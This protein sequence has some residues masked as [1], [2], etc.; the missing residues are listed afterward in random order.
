MANETE[1]DAGKPDANA[2]TGNKPAVV[3]STLPSTVH[4]LP[5]E[6]FDSRFHI[7]VSATFTASGNVVSIIAPDITS[8][9]LKLYITAPIRITSD[10]VLEFLKA[11]DT[12]LDSK[13]EER[14]KT[15][16]ASIELSAFYY[17]RKMEQLDFT[18]DTGDAKLKAYLKDALK[19]PDAT[20]TDPYIKD[21]K[22]R[23]E[24]KGQTGKY[25]YDRGAFLVM[26]KLSFEQ[27]IISTLVGDP[28]ISKLFDVTD[29]H[30]RV[31]R[32]PPDREGDLQ[33]YAQLLSAG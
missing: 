4:M 20:V 28:S 3:G 1:A 26:F 6:V 10:A 23:N 16:K 19:V 12:V 18:N 29:I 13:I 15:A 17:E 11:R 2:D 27:G 5:A 8:D 7:G 14:L 22:A 30:V 32:C 9:G 25:Q 31:L 33:Q 21:W 24:I